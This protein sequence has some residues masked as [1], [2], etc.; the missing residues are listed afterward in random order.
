[1]IRPG[2]LAMS[3]VTPRALLIAAG[4]VI[5]ALLAALGLD[6]CASVTPTPSASRALAPTPSSGLPTMTVATLPA[7]AR[8]VL[9]VIDNGGPFRYRQ[10]DT[11][12][13]N[14]EGLLPKRP[15][16]YYREYTVVTPGSSDRGERRLVV[17]RNGDV[18]YTSDHYESFR[19]VLR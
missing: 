17:G 15:S 7:P 16:G 10:D 18:Y 19:Q 11:V 2:R 12:F 6:R 3:S 8:S 5:V 1:V 14:F 4:I 13:G 9:A